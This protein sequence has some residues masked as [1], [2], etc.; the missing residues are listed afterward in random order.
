MLHIS[1][2]IPISWS[3]CLQPGQEQTHAPRLRKRRIVMA[4]HVKRIL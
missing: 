4:D 1:R 2:D 3:F